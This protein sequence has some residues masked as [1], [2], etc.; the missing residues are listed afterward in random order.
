VIQS[1]AP[2]V[3]YKSSFRFRRWVVT[4]IAVLGGIFWNVLAAAI[5]SFRVAYTWCSPERKVRL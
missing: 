2:P 1:S 3:E 5:L 4:I